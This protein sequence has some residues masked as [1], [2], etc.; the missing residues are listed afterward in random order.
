[1]NRLPP[2]PSGGAYAIRAPKLYYFDAETNTQIHEYLTDP[3]CLHDYILKHSSSSRVPLVKAKPLWFELGR[4]IGDWLL[5][6][7]RWAALPEQVQL[8]EEVKGN[9]EIRKLKYHLIYDRL[10]AAADNFP[11]IFADVKDT[12]EEIR[13]RAAEELQ[14]PDLLLVHGDFWTGKWVATLL[15]CCF[16]GRPKIRKLSNANF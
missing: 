8:R 9:E 11:T 10:V 16:G 5:G 13:K 6:F 4:S 1:M 2:P 7:H 3:L 15:S 12:L 14:I